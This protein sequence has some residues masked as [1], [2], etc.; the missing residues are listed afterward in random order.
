VLGPHD[1]RNRWSSVG[2]SGHGRRVRIAGHGTLTATTPDDEAASHRVRI[3]PDRSPKHGDRS[4]KVRHETTPVS[5]TCVTL[6]RAGDGSTGATAVA[7]DLLPGGPA[8]V[9]RARR[10]GRG[11]VELWSQPLRRARV[12]SGIR[13]L[14]GHQ[15]KPRGSLTKP[16]GPMGHLLPVAESRTTW[17]LRSPPQAAR[18]I[19]PPRSRTRQPIRGAKPTLWGLVAPDPR[20]GRCP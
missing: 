3:P 8:G 16:T 19:G 11:R 20:R 13:E 15:S 5:T 10:C 18:P 7:A 1:I 9:G 12:P 6:R 2:T 14:S 17:R 4:W